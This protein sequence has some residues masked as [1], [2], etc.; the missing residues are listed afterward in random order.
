MKKIIKNNFK[1]FLKML[2]KKC[3]VCYNIIIRTEANM[4]IKKITLKAIKKM[5]EPL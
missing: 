5:A 2:D 1:N 4:E 3:Y